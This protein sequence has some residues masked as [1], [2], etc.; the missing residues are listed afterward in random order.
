MKVELPDFRK[1]MENMTDEEMREQMKKMNVLP[2]RPWQERTPFL[3]ATGGI[4]EP[5]VPPEGDGKVS[6]ITKQAS[7]SKL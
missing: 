4:F 6:P 7:S 1:K 5:Y 3:H 2:P